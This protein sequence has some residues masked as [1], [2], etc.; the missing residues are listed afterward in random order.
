MTIY[1]LFQNF[2]NNFNDF[3]VLNK[4]TYKEFTHGLNYIPFWYGNLISELI[5]KQNKIGRKI[6]ESEVL[7]AIKYLKNIG[8]RVNI[9][10]IAE[11]VGCHATIHKGFNKIY[12]NLK[13]LK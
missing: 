8:E 4:L 6:N 1:H 9:I 7:G 10:N 5:P 2:P 12:K 11:I 3:I 13:L